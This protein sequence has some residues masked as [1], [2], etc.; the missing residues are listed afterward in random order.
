MPDDII[1][2]IA[3]DELLRVQNASIAIANENQKIVWYNQSFKDDIGGVRIKGN[4]FVTMFSIP[5]NII[6]TTKKSIKPYFHP[7]AN[8]NFTA[9]ITPI[10]SKAKTKKQLGYFI[11]LIPSRQDADSL[12]LDAELTFPSRMK[13]RNC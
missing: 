2:R 5:E 1:S 10:L 6:H 9:S 11:E 8:I 3:A 4:N 13:W 12:G 7:L